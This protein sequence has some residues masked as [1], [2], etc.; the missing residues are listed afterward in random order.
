M[1][2]VFVTI[3]VVGPKLRR[4]LVIGTCRQY[5][6]VLTTTAYALAD[7]DLMRSLRN[8]GEHDVHDHYTAH[9]QEDGYHTHRGGRD[10]AGELV[11]EI[12]QGVGGQGR[13]RVVLLWPEMTVGTQQH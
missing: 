6:N 2:V 7:A 9:H 1:A 4:I 10:R 5:M 12:Y 11:P 3:I 13:K 8:Y